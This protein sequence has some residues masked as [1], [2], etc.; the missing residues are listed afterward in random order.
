MSSFYTDTSLTE[1][2]YRVGSKN[3]DFFLNLQ[4]D[5]PQLNSVL[6][7]NGLNWKPTDISQVI[8]TYTLVFDAGNAFDLGSVYLINP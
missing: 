1:L 8:A 3:A 7:F 4:V 2:G 5:N 6:L